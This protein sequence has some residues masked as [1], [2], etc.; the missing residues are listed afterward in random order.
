M[1]TTRIWARTR[2]GKAGTKAIIFLEKLL[3]GSFFCW[4]S[5]LR[6]KVKINSGLKIWLPFFEGAQKNRLQK[7][8]ALSKWFEFDLYS[9]TAL[10]TRS[11]ASLSKIADCTFRPLSSISFLASSAL[12]P[13]RRTIIG[14]LMLP[15]F[16]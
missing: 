9:A 1:P 3:K 12:V 8:P 2:S 6:N 14:M 5:H 7:Q 16:W 4:I 11:A 10:A 13:C 15:I